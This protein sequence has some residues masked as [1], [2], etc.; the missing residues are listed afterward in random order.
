MYNPEHARIYDDPVGNCMFG[1][2]ESS[3]RE[4]DGSRMTNK[5]EISSS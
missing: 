2:I 5:E 4:R 3:K 1:W